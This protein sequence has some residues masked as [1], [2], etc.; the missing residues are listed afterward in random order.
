MDVGAS[1]K[2]AYVA[3]ELEP[4]GTISELTLTPTTSPPTVH[5]YFA[6]T[7]DFHYPAGDPNFNFS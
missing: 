6:T 2:P 7:G 4:L 3:P 1:P 5:K